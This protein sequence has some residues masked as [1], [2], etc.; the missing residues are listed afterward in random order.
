MIK[1]SFKITKWNGPRLQQHVRF[2]FGKYN[3]EVSKKFK[4]KIESEAFEWP[5]VTIR[6]NGSV[7]TSPR[8][9]VDTGAFIASQNRESINA[10]TTL[11]TWGV[12]YSSLILTGY[13]TRSGSQMP[14]RDWITPVI[15]DEF[16]MQ[17]YFERQFKRLGY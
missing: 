5:N 16:R 7:V 12:P 8:N 3:T 1:S 6:K 9:I 17:D 10:T 2:V 11:F 14:A 15:K 4:D 13:T